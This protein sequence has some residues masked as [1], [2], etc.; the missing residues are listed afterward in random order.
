MD[1]NNHPL[2]IFVILNLT[3]YE[4]SKVFDQRSEQ[5]VEAF[6]EYAVRGDPPPGMTW[7]GSHYNNRLTRYLQVQR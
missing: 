4:I 2:A 5:V 3:T 6:R 1:P 7:F